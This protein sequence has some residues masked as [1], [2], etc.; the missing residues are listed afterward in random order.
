MI[1]A[2]ASLGDSRMLE[3][4]ADLRDLENQVLRVLRGE[5]PVA[6][7]AIAERAVILADDLLPS[8]FIALDAGRIAGVCI[9]RGGATSHVALLAA[10]SGVSALVAAGPPLLRNSPPAAPPARAPTRR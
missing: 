7:R 9:A 8:Q 1:E 4:A 6:A 3:R 10:A 5:A 2:L